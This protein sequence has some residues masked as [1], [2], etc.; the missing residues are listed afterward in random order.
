MNAINKQNIGD[1]LRDFDHNRLS[2]NQVEQLLAFLELNPD[3]DE[4]M[5][6]DALKLEPMEV[7]N[8]SH[9]AFTHLA[10]QAETNIALLAFRIAENDLVAEEE[11]WMEEL[12]KHYPALQAEINLFEKLQLKPNLNTVY[13]NKQGLKHTSTIRT[14]YKPLVGI[15]ATLL[16]LFGVSYHWFPSPSVY[17]Q[18]LS[19][20]EIIPFKKPAL[21]LIPQEEVSKETS[22]VKA[23]KAKQPF[24]KDLN[25]HADLI[26]MDK[27]PLAKMMIE[28]NYHADKPSIEKAKTTILIS[29][30]QH[31]NR[32]Q[33][34]WNNI[35]QDAVKIVSRSKN[36]GDE[37]VSKG[38]FLKEQVTSFVADAPERVRLKQ[39]K[40]IRVLG[41]NII[42]EPIALLK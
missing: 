2:E 18:R 3:Y 36:Q 10:Q 15:A 1:W 14:F 9:V 38:T 20:L 27:L 6:D 12:H 32:L 39:T 25:R 5:S 17:Q 34:S 23:V 29:V 7:G 19:V 21:M 13:P 22:L 16:V 42:L 4:L 30:Q 8:V 28:K 11:K 26:S 24:E 37:I 40:M 33:S 31:P 41:A 35:K